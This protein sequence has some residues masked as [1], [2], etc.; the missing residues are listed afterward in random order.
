M[1]KSTCQACKPELNPKDP[2]GERR[3]LTTSDLHTYIKV[4]KFV[5]IMYKLNTCNEEK[6]SKN[7]QQGKATAPSL[8]TAIQP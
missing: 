6:Q 4:I 1:H 3:E 8:T 7:G 5:H 2:Q